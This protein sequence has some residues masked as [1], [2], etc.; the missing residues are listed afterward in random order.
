MEPGSHKIDVSIEDEMKTSYIDYAMSVIIGR[1]LPDV[2]DGLKPVHRRTLFAMHELKNNWNAAYKKSARVVGDVIGKY[3]PHGDQ[4]VYDTIV[5]MAQTFSMRYLLVDG[6][7]NFGSVDGDPAAAMRYTEVRMS[8]LAHELLADI[9]KETVDFGPNYDESLQ[10][11]L[12]LPARAPNL[13]IN[14]SEGIAVGMATKIPP[15]NLREIV[16]ATVRLIR[17]PEL[18]NDD[19][20]TTVTGP[21][22]PTGAYILGTGGIA[23]AY[24]TGRGI[25]HMRAKHHLEEKANGESIIFDELPFQVNKARL[26]ERIAELVKEKRIEGIRDLRDESDRRGM[27]MVVEL[28]R[29]AIADVVLNQLFKMTPLQGSFGIILLAIV[30]GRPRVLTLRDCLKHF[31]DHRRT[32][33]TRRCQYELRRAEARAH[34]LEGLLIALDNIEAIIKTIRASADAPIAKAALMSGFGLSELQAQA[35]LDMR[36][37]RLTGLE[38]D[39]IRAEYEELKTE[40]ERLTAILGDE[41]LLMEVIVGELDEIEERYGD[42]RRTEILPFAGVIDDESLIPEERMV[43][44]VSNQGYIK[45]VALSEY[46]AQ[47]RGGKGKASMRTKDEDFVRDL[48]VEST[49]SHVLIFTSLGRVFRLKVWQLPQGSRTARG[50]AVVNLLNLMEGEEMTALRPVAEWPEEM[51]QKFLFFCT[52]KGRVKKTDL[53]AYHNIRSNGLYAI[54]LEDDDHLIEVSQVDP[55]QDVILVSAD[56]MSI[57]FNSDEARP[58]GRRTRGVRGMSLRPGDKV[59][60]MLPVWDD[61]GDLLTATE[62]GYGKRTPTSDYRAQKRAGLGLKDI[63]TGP[64]NG[65]VIGAR[66]VTDDDEIIFVT[67]G[68]TLIRIGCDEVRQIG[69]NTKG[70]ILIRVDDDETLVGLAKAPREEEQEVGS[71]DPGQG[72]ELAPASEDAPPEVDAGDDAG[73]DSGAGQ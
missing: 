37:Q 63:K 15:H 39:K 3:H 34:I 47:R 24:R 10:E 64:R 53:T 50:K 7:G 16:Q 23:E 30:R 45:R 59:V 43:V 19:L 72:G 60:G 8:R 44:T 9:E 12:L 11:P 62:R 2:R 54:E 6:Q 65:K 20:M 73:D 58:M 48:F 52:R 51:G 14:G 42:E 21:D 66:S 41:G 69:R 49:H 31:I 18:T 57:R 4:A 28:R 36:L 70:V 46:S 56:G 26:L 27:R 22:F 17:D 32:V 35:I 55:S 5:R 13:L 38:R 68:G 29:D 40:I 1:A 71:E 67:D 25:V 61:D 33:V